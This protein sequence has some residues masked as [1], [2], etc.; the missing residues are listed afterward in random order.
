MVHTVA[1]ISHMILQKMEPD[2]EQLNSVIPNENS[3]KGV[4]PY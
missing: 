3:N 1:S 2:F 4:T